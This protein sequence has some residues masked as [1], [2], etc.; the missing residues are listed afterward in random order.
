MMAEADIEHASRVGLSAA[1]LHSDTDRGGC[2]AC[3]ECLRADPAV[4]N[5]RMMKESK[6]SH[7]F[8]KAIQ[9]IETK[10]FRDF[11]QADVFI[12]WNDRRRC[13]VRLQDE[14]YMRA[15][16]CTKIVISVSCR[17]SK[18]FWNG[19]KKGILTMRSH[20]RRI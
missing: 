14:C 12:A 4:E 15:G 2:P 16:D 11:S 9:A 6:S 5:C 19:V 10:S 8:F 13:I 1:A 20:G 17:C 18:I 7:W 3:P